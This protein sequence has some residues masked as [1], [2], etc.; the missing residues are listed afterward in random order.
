MRGQ[1]LQTYNRACMSSHASSHSRCLAD[2]DSL[3]CTLVCTAGQEA[4]YVYGLAM[5]LCLMSDKWQ[6]AVQ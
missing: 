6:H 3:G 4:S 5:L 2:L 1:N